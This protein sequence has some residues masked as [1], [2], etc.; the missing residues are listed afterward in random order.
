MQNQEPDPK[1]E[2]VEEPREE[3]LDETACSPSSTPIT[4]A[5]IESLCPFMES[6]A[7]RRLEELARQL[8]GEIVALQPLHYHEWQDGC[9]VIRRG[10]GEWRLEWCKCGANREKAGS[11][12]FIT[13]NDQI[14]PRRA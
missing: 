12:K 10:E 1:P 9:R 14:H 2:P 7:T 11:R 4:D 13:E 8:E 5:L 6:N 3:G